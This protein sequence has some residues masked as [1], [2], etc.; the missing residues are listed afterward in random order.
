MKLNYLY[1][2]FIFIY[3]YLIEFQ[4]NNVLSNPL[5]NDV[6]LQIMKNSLQIIGGDF[7]RTGTTSLKSSLEI[8]GFN[9]C[10]H[11]KELLV[12]PDQLSCFGKA[13]E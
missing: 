11:M 9:K 4:H 8:L 5:K 2:L 10:Y 6:N 13:S 12:D 3:I 1:F 7:T